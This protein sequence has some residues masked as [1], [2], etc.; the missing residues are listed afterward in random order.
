[1]KALALHYSRPQRAGDPACLLSPGLCSTVWHICQKE[2][3]FLP[4]T[5][6]AGALRVKDPQS[7]HH[8]P[9]ESG[10]THTVLCLGKGVC[11]GHVPGPILGS[12]LTASLK[13]VNLNSGGS[14]FHKNLMCQSDLCVCSLGRVIKCFS[15]SK[16]G[17]KIRV[18]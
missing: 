15:A 5:L 10:A 16:T 12:L 18:R 1:M 7:V 11:P 9:L 8:G 2:G 6:T 17:M 14:L 13:L 3:T 4:E